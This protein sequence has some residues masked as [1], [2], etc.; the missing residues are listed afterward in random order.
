MVA[1]LGNRLERG[2][3]DGVNPGLRSLWILLV[4]LLALGVAG[5]CV[6]GST[7]KVWASPAD[8]TFKLE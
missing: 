1:R 4:G 5:V 3:R 7:V 2:A 6:S 8:T